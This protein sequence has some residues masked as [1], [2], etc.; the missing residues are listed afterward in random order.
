MKL[1]V[2]QMVC[3]GG[4]GGSGAIV[5]V[6]VVAAV[7]SLWYWDIQLSIVMQTSW[8]YWEW[9]FSALR[10]QFCWRYRKNP[11][12]TRL[13]RARC[14]PPTRTSSASAVCPPF[15]LCWFVL[16]LSRFMR[17]RQQQWKKAFRETQTLRAGC[18]KAE[19]KIFALPQTPFRGHRIAKISSAGDGH[20][21]HPQTK[22]G[23]NRCTQFRVIVVT[24]TALPPARHK[25]NDYNTLRRYA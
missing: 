24:D 4:G 14:W 16:S 2:Y 17:R 8:I 3:G 1:N 18:S 7:Q 10:R 13:I 21:L 20:Y 5:V 11:T 15:E 6:V 23:D 25:R 19:P 22:F 9:S 12:R